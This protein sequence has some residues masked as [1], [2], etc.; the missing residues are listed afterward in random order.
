ML[1]RL[2]ASDAWA[3]AHF[4]SLHDSTSRTASPWDVDRDLHGRFDFC[5]I[6]R[7]RLARI[8]FNP[9]CIEKTRESISAGNLNLYKVLLQVSGCSTL[10]QAARKV[11]LSAGNW[12][13]YRDALPYS[14]VNLERG[15]QRMLI[16]PQSEL[17]SKTLDLDQLAVRCFG[18]HD[19]SSKQLSGVLD[20]AF[21]T[22]SIF[23]AEAASELAEVMIHLARLAL[24]EN[25]GTGTQLL[26]SDVM[27][28]RV[29]SYINRHL[30]DPELS[31][32]GIAA[33]LNCSKRYVHKVFSENEETVSRYIINQRLEKCVAELVGTT[34]RSGSI[35]HIACSWGFNSLS[36][37]GK[38][39]GKR[40]GMSPSEW[41][42]TQDAENIS[43]IASG[44]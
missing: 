20:S 44:D 11:T 6:G 28:R 17:L 31:V 8:R 43:S 37:F 25:S 5:D 34:M 38:V 40:Y 35:A 39:F 26:R 7:V 32:D 10:E 14:L 21:E 15:E 22:T 9:L 27:F 2:S 23:G 24:L 42:R 30:R 1:A 41:R 13:L 3:R 18:T 33:A 19:H 4:T 36:H 29:K 12:T 16:L